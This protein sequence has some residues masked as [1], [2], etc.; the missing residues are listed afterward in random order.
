MPANPETINHL[1]RALVDSVLS[2]NA[3]KMRAMSGYLR[4]IGSLDKDDPQ[5]AEVRDLIR[6]NFAELQTAL[7]EIP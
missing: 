7:A 2:Q 4:L 1:R 3:S 5:A 6:A